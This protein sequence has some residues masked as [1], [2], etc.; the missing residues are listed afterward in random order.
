MN[1]SEIIQNLLQNEK[2]SLVDIGAMGGV[3]ELAGLA[4]WINAIAFEPNQDEYAKLRNSK[5][6]TKYASLNIFNYALSN[7]NGKTTL[8]VNKRASF[9]SLLHADQDVV[10]RHLGLLDEYPNLTEDFK[11]H[12]QIE[13]DV[14]RLDSILPQLG[15]T[16][17]NYM[18][19]DTQGSELLI[20]QG[21]ETLLNNQ[22]IHIIKCEVTFI[23]IYEK[24]ALF[25]DID[26]LL[27]EKGF[28][29]VD[30]IFYPN[31]DVSLKNCFARKIYDQPRYAQGGDAIFVKKITLNDSQIDLIKT[32]LMLASL[33]YFSLA[34]HY[35]KKGMV[36]DSLI[37]HIFKYFRKISPNKSIKSFGKAMTPPILYYYLKSLLARAHAKR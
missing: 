13:V 32:G 22:L 2:I 35:L 9:S 36:S 25:S 16:G 17:I 15:V 20:L 18:K 4:M 28:E 29:F 24:Q 3:T 10:K 23:P 7:S 33:E 19:L 31:H 30:C 21:A 5:N 1:I 34:N 8:N 37:E 6:K 11:K 14:W 26:I 27:R 12:Q